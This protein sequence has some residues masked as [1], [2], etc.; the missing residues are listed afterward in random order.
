MSEK[1]IY[2]RNND[3]NYLGV[4]TSYAHLDYP[5]L[6]LM[7]N[8]AQTLEIQT[9]IKEIQNKIFKYLLHIINR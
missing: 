3:S 1:V 7:R 9:E 2:Q 5:K 6:L 4:M 8:D